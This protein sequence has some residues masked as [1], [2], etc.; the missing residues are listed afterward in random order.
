MP[1]WNW[2][3]Y[4]DT[5][6]ELTTLG[7]NVEECGPGTPKQ[8]LKVKLSI[9]YLFEHS[10]QEVDDMKRDIDLSSQLENDVDKFEHV[11]SCTTKVYH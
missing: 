10:D 3:D 9:D 2:K 6:K 11:C 5:K 7:T 4:D 8:A 1:P